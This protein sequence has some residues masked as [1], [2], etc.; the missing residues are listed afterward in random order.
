[1]L[2]RG[3]AAV[4]CAAAAVPWHVAVSTPWTTACPNVVHATKNG[5]DRSRASC[6]H[7]AAPSRTVAMTSPDQLTHPSPRV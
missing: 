1:M 5:S 4:P 2:D 7:D 6:V 3:T